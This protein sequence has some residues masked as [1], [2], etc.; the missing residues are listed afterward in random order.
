[1]LSAPQWL[2]RQQDHLVRLHEDNPASPLVHPSVRAPLLA[3]QA[4]AEAAGFSLWI[5]SAFRSFDRQLAIWNEKAS[6]QRPVLDDAGQVIDMAALDDRARLHAILRFSALPGTS[7][8]H[9][10]TDVDVYDRAAVPVGYHVQLSQE[11]SRTLFGTFHRWLDERIATGAAHGFF[12][13]Y[14]EDRGGVAPEPWH[15]SHAPT[16]SA[17]DAGVSLAVLREAL[18]AAPLLLKQA[19]LDELDALA[20]RYVAVP[21]ECYPPTCPTGARHV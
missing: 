6:G 12:R 16:A 19:V 17:C 11:E 20:A 10:G 2:G 1:M 4:D 15:L 8:H 14:A 9:W 18:S 13:C 5:A 3:L 7:R 21:P